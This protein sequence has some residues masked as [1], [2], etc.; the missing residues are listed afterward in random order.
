MNKKEIANQMI[1]IA[2]DS[3]AERKAR[4][5]K[6]QQECDDAIV[7]EREQ[8]DMYELQLEAYKKI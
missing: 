8:I 6:H 1:Q 4:I 5:L 2:M 3:I 7:K